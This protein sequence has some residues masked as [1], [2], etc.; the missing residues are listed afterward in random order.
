MK[1][2]NKKTLP[3][4]VCVMLTLLMLTAC[5]GNGVPVEGFPAELR[6]NPPGRAP[7]YTTADVDITLEFLRLESHAIIMLMTND[8][9]Q[10]I[11]YDNGYVLAI[12][13]DDGYPGSHAWSFVPQDGDW[14]TSIIMQPFSL[15]QNNTLPPG[16]QAE[17]RAELDVPLLPDWSGEFRITKTVFVGS[18]KHDL[19]AYFYK[20]DETISDD[21]SGIVAEVLVAEPG[22]AVIKLTN[23][24]DSG[25]LFFD[26]EYRVERNIR[27]T[28]YE[29][30]VKNTMF[31]P[32]GESSIG[33]KQKR[34]FAISWGWL[35]GELARGEYRI[36][37]SFWHY[38]DEVTR[39]DLYIPFSLDGRTPA[40]QGVWAGQ[41]E[42]QNTFRAEVEAIEPALSGVPSLLVRTLTHTS[43]TGEAG[44]RVYIWH[45]HTVNALDANG[46]PIPF[47]D[48]E[49]G[50]TVEIR[51]S[52]SI[53]DSRPGQIGDAFLIRVIG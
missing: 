17:V 49:I 27:G 32:E 9:N 3:V 52:G 20:A 33:P 12:F 5:A 8:T 25:R 31:F 2:L 53:M 38:T 14:A 13:F 44:S 24:F 48:I 6:T 45:N 41:F 10:D 21:V 34:G 23:G 50:A 4:A 35:Y 22:G 30:P 29:A 7:V 1:M 36:A 47:F 11:E 37:K 28:W 26:R 15:M 51:H 40:E 42:H 16:E 39:Y 19:H 18:E 46:K 43:L